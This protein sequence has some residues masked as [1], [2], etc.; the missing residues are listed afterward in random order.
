MLQ[1]IE[2]S[3]EQDATLYDHLGDIYTSLKQI[4]Q[5]REAWTKSLAI[6]AN[7]QVEQKLK[8]AASP[9]ATGP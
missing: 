9:P 8:S 5:A 1:A 4:Q 3:E 6:E 7:P 2:H